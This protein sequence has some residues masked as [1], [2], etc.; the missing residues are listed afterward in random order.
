MSG[1]P[2]SHVAKFGVVHLHRD[3]L[4]AERVVRPNSQRASE[5]AKRR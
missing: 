4:K 3:P 2:R 5:K 1:Q